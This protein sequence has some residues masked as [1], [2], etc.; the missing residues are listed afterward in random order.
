M[1][2][3]REAHIALGLLASGC[4]YTTTDMLGAPLELTA[5]EVNSGIRSLQSKLDSGTQ[6][7]DAFIRHDK[8]YGWLL[9]GRPARIDALYQEAMTAIMYDAALIEAD[10]AAGRIIPRFPFAVPQSRLIEAVA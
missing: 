8:G 1:M 5:V 9:Y 4:A 7:Q 6:Q 2:T 10:N 3:R